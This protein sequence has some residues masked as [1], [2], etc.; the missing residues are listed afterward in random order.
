[1][2]VKFLHYF[3]KDCYMQPYNYTNLAAVQA[4]LKELVKEEKEF[5]EREKIG[6]SVV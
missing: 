6:S 2:Q 4:Y 1:M 3:W 5:A